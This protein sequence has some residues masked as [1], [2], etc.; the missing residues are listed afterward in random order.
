MAVKA[1]SRLPR[2]SAAGRA[3]ERS[4]ALTAVGEPTSTSLTVRATDHTLAVTVTVTGDAD[5]TVILA[6]AAA[7]SERA[8]AWPF[9]VID[10]CNGTPGSR[11]TVKS[12]GDRMA[13]RSR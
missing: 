11:P 1:P 4:I 8:R 13:D 12:A 9:V 10:L 6:L 7:L 5:A 3:L 2:P